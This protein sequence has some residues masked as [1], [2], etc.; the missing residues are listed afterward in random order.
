MAAL[1]TSAFLCLLP[2]AACS[3]PSSLPLLSSADD[4]AALSAAFALLSNPDYCQALR[5]A[6]HLEGDRAAALTQTDTSRLAARYI[7]SRSVVDASSARALM[8]EAFSQ[9]RVCIV[10]EFSGA[11]HPPYR[12]VDSF[13]SHYKTLSRA[14]RVYDYRSANRLHFI[15]K[16]EVGSSSPSDRIASDWWSGVNLLPNLGLTH[17]LSGANLWNFVSRRAKSSLHIDESDGTCTQ[18]LGKKLWVLARADEARA[19]GIE[20]LRS[21]AMR[22][23]PDGI[24]TLAAWL[25]CPS[26][27]WCVLSEGD[28]IFTPI[29]RLHAVSCIGDIDAISCGSYCWLDGTAPP[30]SWSM[31]ASHGAS[32]L[33]SP[34]V[35]SLAA[36]SSS[37]LAVASRSIVACCDSYSDDFSVTVHESGKH[38]VFSGPHDLLLH[39]ECLAPLIMKRLRV[40]YSGQH[41]S[42]RC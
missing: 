41:S 5:N 24:H 7:H 16:S 22:K 28:T 17:D 31:Q 29:D 38:R 11:F 21:D 9:S 20:P 26:F 13:L 3:L 25:D 42:T 12:T 36:F 32:A 35:S 15:F 6:L 2:P 14:A 30:P 18:W 34:T 33:S 8:K 19:H 39:N 37:A 4:A 10:R 23:N 1:N 40:I 27:Q